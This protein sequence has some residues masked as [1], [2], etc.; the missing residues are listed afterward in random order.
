[1]PLPELAALC[2]ACPGRRT[3]AATQSYAIKLVHPDDPQ[4][5]IQN[6]DIDVK[7]MPL[8][9]LSKTQVQKGYDILTELKS[10]ISSRKSSDI[11]TL[12]SRFYTVIPHNFG[13]NRPPLIDTAEK[14]QT[15]FVLT[16]MNPNKVLNMT[17][18]LLLFVLDHK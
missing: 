10:A 3:C 1:M 5:V 17:H 16:P 9:N 15:K 14:L 11:A 7:K 18:K 2:T 4:I 13:R 8:G 12:T 6:F